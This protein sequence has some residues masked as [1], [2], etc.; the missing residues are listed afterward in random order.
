MATNGR[1]GVPPSVPLQ[2]APT[3]SPCSHVVQNPTGTKTMTCSSQ[4]VSPTCTPATKKSPGFSATDFDANLCALAS[5][6]NRAQLHLSQHHVLNS[7]I[8]STNPAAI[9]AITNLCPHPG[10][11]FSREFCTTPTQFLSIFR[12]MRITIGWCRSRSLAVAA[13]STL[14]MTLP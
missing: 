12:N 9:Q 11:P 3:T 8:F 7:T 10:Q 2:S 6:A 14:P 13:A 4:Q 1:P 5:A